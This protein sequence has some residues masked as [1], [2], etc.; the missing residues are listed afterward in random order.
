MATT[1]FTSL[2]EF[3]KSAGHSVRYIMPP[4]WDLVGPVDAN[5]RVL[6]VGCGNGYIAS[7][8][9]KKGCR[10]VGIDADPTR[11]EVARQLYPQL[12]FE[13][14]PADEVLLTKLNEPPFDV[15]ISTEVVEHLY[16]PQAFCNG[17]FHATK[18]G[19][20]CVI[21]TPYHGYLKN[22]AIAMSGKAD[23]H[24][25][26]LWEGGH[27]KF[28]SRKTLEQLMQESGFRN[29]QF[30]GAGRM[31]GLWMSMLMSGERPT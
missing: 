3:E 26:P 23:H 28:F 30:R 5:T 19:G 27:I 16:A 25:N 4:M 12:R 11:I 6:D 9:A 18:P 10:V 20:R 22:L 17:C 15:V 8:F 29:M 31:P 24:Y 13:A 2:G 7:L 1:Q 14:L 21:S